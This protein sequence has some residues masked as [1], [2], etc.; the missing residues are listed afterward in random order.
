VY[1]LARPFLFCLAAE[2]AH[3]LALLS[4]ETAYST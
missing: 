3:D 2:R 1:S 4:I